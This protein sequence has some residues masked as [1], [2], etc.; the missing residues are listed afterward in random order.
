MNQQLTMKKLIQ[1]CLLLLSL[2]F[3]PNAT[4][5]GKA[6]GKG[7]K[8]TFCTA[9]WEPMDDT[10]YYLKGGTA[11]NP[12]FEQISLTEM[13][14]SLPYQVKAERSLTFYK[15]V[16]QEEYVKALTVKLPVIS[17]GERRYLLLFMPKE[18]NQYR[19]I[20]IRDSRKDSPFG[21][22][23]FYNLSV[24]P[25]RGR[26]NNKI[27]DIAKGQQKL[28]VLNLKSGS[29]MPFATMSVVK[30]KKQWLQ[31]NTFHFNPKKHSKFFLHQIP[32]ANGKFKIKA[33]AIVEFEPSTKQPTVSP[34]G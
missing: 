34:P 6:D 10:F 13:C 28:I 24:L 14:R 15:K 2:L 19:V 8:I 23:V 22:Y 29:P 4:A 32:T 17:N 26:L 5:Q 33:K 31:R 21:A 30:G 20:V 11:E 7:P 9:S 18:D 25:I 1:T 27:F 12:Q 16:N 3:L